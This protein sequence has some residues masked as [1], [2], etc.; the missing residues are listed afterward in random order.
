M[1][2]EVTAD[3]LHTL[4]AI[5]P[6]AIIGLDEQ[7]RVDL[8]NEAA[9]A[10][11]GWPQSEVRGNALPG[12]LDALSRVGANCHPLVVTVAGKDGREFAVESRA[13][14]RGLGGLVIAASDLSH[15]ATQERER[16][17]LLE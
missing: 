4:N 6:V 13:A 8:C 15:A 12:E 11:F 3:T 14:L 1:N 2:P 9:V 10:L 16:L 17:E 5:S 7:G